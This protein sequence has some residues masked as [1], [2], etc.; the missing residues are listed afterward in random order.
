MERIKDIL[1]LFLVGTLFA[2]CEKY[3]DFTGDDVPER[4]VL[5]GRIQ[6]DSVFSIELSN[7]LGY[8][9]LGVIRGI[10]NARVDV[11]NGQGQFMETLTDFGNGIYR[12]TATAAMGETYTVQASAANFPE[13]SAVDNV[14]FA[15]PI[16]SWDTAFVTI[17]EFQPEALEIT[18]GLS[19]PGDLDNFYMIE[20][21]QVQLYYLDFVGFDPNTGNAIYDTIY[22]E[23]PVRQQIFFS[24]TDV[25]LTSE[26]DVG[27]GEVRVY[28][29]RFV[30]SDILFNGTSRQFKVDVDFFDPSGTLELRLTSCS[31]DFFNYVRTLQRFEY[32]NGDPFVEPV[33]VF[34]N[35]A[36]GLGIW[37]GSAPSVVY[38]EF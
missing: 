16:S 29:D 9:D 33:L 15:V 19:D 12:G 2:G 13:I 34:N 3:I 26:F 32:T 7:S 28:N 27:L 5:N 31:S 4:L 20:V 36:G 6:A 37:G 14:P 11:L 38:I 23:N 18:F 10:E 1:I 35:V 24:T 22:Y 25:I 8:T 17:D 30:F 21:F